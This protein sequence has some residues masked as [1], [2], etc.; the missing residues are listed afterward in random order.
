MIRRREIHRLGDGERN[1]V[2]WGNI[3]IEEVDEMP[4]IVTR[5]R[6]G[7]RDLRGGG[8]ERVRITSLR[9]EGDHDKFA[10]VH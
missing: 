5:M 9:L 1:L 7:E 6:G 4:V 3:L 10:R 2:R 8:E